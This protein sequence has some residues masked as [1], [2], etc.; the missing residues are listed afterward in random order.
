[1]SSP[2]PS[3]FDPNECASLHNQLVQLVTQANPSIQPLQDV[4]SA[5]A[6][7]ARLSPAMLT[8]LA[9]I[10]SWR[11]QEDSTAI[12]PFCQ[13]P[14]PQSFYHYRSWPQ[15][16]AYGD[17]IILLYPDISLSLE[18]EGG[19]FFDQE[20][21]VACW[22]DPGLGF[23]PEDSW[24][25]LVEILSRWVMMWDVG[26]IRIDGGV[27]MREWGE[28]DLEQAVLAWEGLV[29][30]IEERMPVLPE[31]RSETAMMVEMAVAHQWCEHAFQRE[32]L[33]RARA[34]R[35]PG[36]NVAP[37]VKT[38]S[39]LTFEAIHAN[40]AADSERRLAIGNKPEDDA[41]RQSYR[42]RGL[43]PVLLFPSDARI[44]RPASRRFDDFWGRGSVLLERRA[45]LYLYPEEDWGDAVL[46][47]D[48]K[49]RDTLFT[50]H[51]GWCPWMRARPLATLRE[52][53][54]FWKFLVLDGVW[55]VDADGVVG[56]DGYFSNL[57]GTKKDV[58][59]G[60]V[61]TEVHFGAAWG[62]APAY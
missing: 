61:Q 25:P 49:G 38:W 29:T 26:K 17:A 39:T 59:L 32:F 30:A 1:M 22:I 5:H 7:D 58:E 60:G 36:L 45:G 42:D 3:Q 48:G 28:W 24:M 55:E 44:A 50:Y 6:A 52:V 20:R 35:Y 46:F 16:S 54:T 21:E 9:N 51:S 33:T 57:E 62:V 4:L 14:N 37:G 2:D 41:Q 12:L 11:A 27:C 56:G 40:E 18:N 19:L 15:F 10:S 23:P 34:P 13:P 43:A 53:L 8:F 47:V 31:R